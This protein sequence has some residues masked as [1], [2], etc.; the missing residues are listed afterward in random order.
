[1]A[2]DVEAIWTALLDRLRER[3]AGV[4][5][6]TRNPKPQYGI[7]EYPVVEVLEVDE[8]PTLDG[9]GLPPRLTLSGVLGIGV[10]TKGDA[11]PSSKLNA[12]IKAVREG[13]ERDDFADDANA[14]RHWTDLGFPGLVLTVGRVE[15]RMGEASGEAWAKIDV[16]IE[17]F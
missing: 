14:F 6:F 9:D 16:T 4:S 7:E 17:T 8:D 1:M 13:L 5:T 3:I 2:T 15:K 12:V 10:R 11:V